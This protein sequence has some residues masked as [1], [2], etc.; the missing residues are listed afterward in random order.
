MPEKKTVK[1]KAS[2]RI[3]GKVY[4]AGGDTPS[5]AI[6]N[7]KPAGVAKGFSLLTVS[8]GK[9]AKDRIIGGALTF[10]LFGGG[11]IMREMALKQVSQLFNI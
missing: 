6:S 1:Y 10:R 5:D 4:R 9:I 7:L 8:K 3:L 2:I 11:R